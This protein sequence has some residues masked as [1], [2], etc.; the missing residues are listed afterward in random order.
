MYLD[1]IQILDLNYLTKLS[2]ISATNTSL[3]AN[4]DAPP[5]HLHETSDMKR[6]LVVS[7]G[8]CSKA[9]ELDPEIV[10]HLNTAERVRSLE[11]FLVE[12]VLVEH[13]RLGRDPLL[14]L[15][16]YD[17]VSAHDLFAVS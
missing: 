14:G 8:S 6:Q 10:G 9:N 12:H 3:D 11:L 15:D 4:L 5:D 13:E 16:R 2:E 1:S 17:V 7:L